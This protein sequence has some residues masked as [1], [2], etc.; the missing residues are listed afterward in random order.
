MVEFAGWSMPLQYGSIV[1]EHLATRR[2]AGL[3]DV[4]HMGRLSFLGPAAA[5]FLD[6]LLT[7]SALRLPLGRVR[8]SLIV[9]DSGGTLDD[10]LLARLAALDA[11]TSESGDP[12]PGVSSA[13]AASPSDRYELVV[14]AGN[15]LKI[16]DWFVRH[17][18][19]DPAV[20]FVDRTHETVMF[21]VQGPQAIARF[22]ALQLAARPV[23]SLRRYAAETTRILG[24]PAVVSRTGYTGEDGIEATV[25][26]DSAEALWKALVDAGCRPA[27]L[28]ARDTLRLEAAMPLYGHEL[29]ETVDPFT[30]GLGFAV[31]LDGRDFVGR[32]ALV[33][34]AAAA[35][36]PG[37]P[38]R[39][40]LVLDGRR[41]PRENY[42]LFAGSRRV[43]RVT[44]G[45]FSPTLQRPIAMAYVDGD[46][47]SPDVRLE[48][49]LRG[50][51][52]PVRIVDLPFYSARTAVS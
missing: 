33:E 44:S 25:E 17:G 24:S 38:R 48:V 10:V 40:G 12:E 41:T 36:T 49:D 34:R 5:S 50:V 52:E 1:D 32:A 20:G 43:G 7:R 19:L 42:E 3:F 28:G 39:V 13:A 6:R 51:R 9:D 2:D 8:Y 35:R 37:A 31:D 21:A 11:R 16:V 30:A 27:G 47:V 46:A 22:D 15:R 45:T 26:V 18:A 14:N 29:D 23:A 4:S